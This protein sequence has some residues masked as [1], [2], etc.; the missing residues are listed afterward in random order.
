[1]E[2][3]FYEKE[4]GDRELGNIENET[5]EGKTELIIF[6]GAKFSSPMTLN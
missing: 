2:R 5:T 4:G 1:M 3:Q 6:G